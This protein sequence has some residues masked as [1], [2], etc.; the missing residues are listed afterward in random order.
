[1]HMPKH[2]M[3]GSCPCESNRHVVSALPLTLYACHRTACQTQSASAFGISI[4]VK[5]AA[6]EF[7]TTSLIKHERI[8]TSGRGVV[9]WFCSDCG[10]R[11]YNNSLRGP[12]VVNIKPVALVDTSWLSPVGHLRL[13]SAQPW[14]Q[15][16]ADALCDQGQPPSFD[17]LY[18]RFKSSYGA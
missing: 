3:T 7:E 13:A 8:A 9:D 2:P 5:R 16:Q 14:F 11:L 10:T 12:D 15:P 1:M 18:E 6:L 4:P 17:A